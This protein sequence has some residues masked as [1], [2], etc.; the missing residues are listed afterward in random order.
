MSIGQRSQKVS[1]T[2]RVVAYF[3][4]RIFSAN[5]CRSRLEMQ[6]KTVKP[7]VSRCKA[8]CGHSVNRVASVHLRELETRCQGVCRP[9]SRRAILTLETSGSTQKNTGGMENCPAS[10]R[11][12]SAPDSARFCLAW[13]RQSAQEKSSAEGSKKEQ[14]KRRASQVTPAR[15]TLPRSAGRFKGFRALERGR[16]RGSHLNLGAHV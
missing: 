4:G 12:F 11:L 16:M 10:Q 7:S 1:K 3:R 9:L 2:V 13:L 5:S 8:F 6:P 15:I 14:D